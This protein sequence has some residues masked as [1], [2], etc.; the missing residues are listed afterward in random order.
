MWELRSRASRAY[1]L[2]VMCWAA[3]DRLSLIADYIAEPER[4]RDWR[5]KAIR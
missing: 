5:E 2:G 1:D 4:A 3:L